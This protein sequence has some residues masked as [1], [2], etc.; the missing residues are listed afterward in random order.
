MALLS[1][2]IP[3]YNEEDN[4]IPFAMRC[5]AVFDNSS[6][7]IEYVFVNDGSADATYT[8]VKELIE[9]KSEYIASD[10]SVVGITFS[11]NFGKESAILA[12][13]ENASGDYVCVIDADLQQ[14]PKYALE[15]VQFLEQNMS[16][17]CVACYQE[18]RK[19]SAL[20]RFCKRRFYHIINK[21]SDTKFEENASDFRTMRRGM[22]E[23][24]MRM[25]EYN[26][27]SKGIF[28]WVGFNTFYMPYEVHER[29]HGRSSWSFIKLTKYAI[30]GF[31]NFSTMPL[32]VATWLGGT[33]SLIAFIYMIVVIIQRFVQDTTIS[34]Y[35]TIVCLLLILGGMQ[36]L[37]LGIIGEYVARMYLETKHRPVY[38]I[39]EKI[40]R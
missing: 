38:I 6:F 28:S 24:I 13:L 4:I 21:I 31:I 18:E 32:K 22:V 16:Y 10:N 29:L 37:F 7:Q 27:F 12:G 35:A 33:I 23:A 2:V 39:K 3:A 34:G 9:R 1:L 25:P 8:K 30:E 19:E 20:L 40:K 11:R 15:M 5:E 26:R 36:I 17:D 14:D